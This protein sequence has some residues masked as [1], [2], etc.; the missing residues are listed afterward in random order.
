MAALDFVT[1]LDALA[2][3]PFQRPHGSI[4]SKPS[5]CLESKTFGRKP[6]AQSCARTLA[7]IVS[8]LIIV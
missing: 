2:R 7:R 3:Y 1:G 8:V 4:G 6:L 5:A